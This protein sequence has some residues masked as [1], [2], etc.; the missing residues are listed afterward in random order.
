VIRPATF[1]FELAQQAKFSA[2]QR[3][4]REGLTLSEMRHEYV[5]P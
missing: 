4:E 2:A 1:F 5:P 3:I